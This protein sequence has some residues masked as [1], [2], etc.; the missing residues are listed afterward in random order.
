MFKSSLIRQLVLKRAQSTAFKRPQLVAPEVALAQVK[1]QLNILKHSP[2]AALI[3]KRLPYRSGVLAKKQGMVPYF[4]EKTGN[5]Y[6]ATVLEMNNVEVILNRTF[7]E[8]GYYAN[9]IGYGDVSPK[10]LTRALLGH[11]SSKEVNPKLEVAE[12]RVK[13]EKGLLPPATLLKPSWFREGQYVDCK[14]VS[15]GKGF[16]G[17][18][19][20]HNFHGQPAS[21]GNSKTHRHGGSIGQNQTPGRVLPGTKMPGHMGHQ[22]CTLQKLEV[23]KVD[24]KL[25]VILIKGSVAGPK[26]AMVKIMDTIKMDPLFGIKKAEYK[27]SKK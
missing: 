21:H 11:F 18:M 9:Q 22:N 13:D 10:K 15:K 23:L 4:D 1:P 19:K 27:A 25:G 7:A 8:H 12:F 17:V 26:G 20:R 14:S 24:D 3:R 6:P 2:E 16:Q 5:R